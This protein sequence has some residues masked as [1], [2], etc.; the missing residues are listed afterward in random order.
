MNDR[1]VVP[2]RVDALALTQ[3][4]DV[5][6][7]SA[8]VAALPWFDGQRDHFARTPNLASA[9]NAPPFADHGARLQPGVHLHW[10]LPAGLTKGTT[11]PELD[12][13][14]EIDGITMPPA[15][16]RWLVRRLDPN[17]GAQWLIESDFVHSIQHEARHAVAFR[18]TSDRLPAVL[19]H[20]RIGRAIPLDNVNASGA[21]AESERLSTEEPWNFL[22]FVH[23]PLTALG[24]GDP[25]F[26][27]MYPAS[28]TVFGCHD[29]GTVTPG[30]ARYEVFGWYGGGVQDPLE[31]FLSSVLPMSSE[32]ALGLLNRRLALDGKTPLGP[33]QITG[34]ELAAAV[35]LSVKE[36]F[37]WDWEVPTDRVTEPLRLL[38]YGQV[39]VHTEAWTGRR[40]PVRHPHGTVV[41]VAD[42]PGE[43][44]GA[45]L[46]SSYPPDERAEIERRIA[47]LELADLL[48]ADHPDAAAKLAEARH[49]NRFS[50]VPG[51][52]YWALRPRTG[53]SGPVATNSGAP[54]APVPL[55][56]LATDLDALNEIQSRLDASRDEY[57][58]R[59]QELFA[60]W[61]RLMTA[62]YP[63]DASDPIPVDVDALRALIERDHLGP[64]AEL[65]ERGFA[66]EAR[67][68]DLHG[69]MGADL[70]AYNDGRPVIQQLELTL[71]PGA[72]FWRP[73]D[74]VVLLGDAD[75]MPIERHGASLVDG[76]LPVAKALRG[77]IEDFSDPHYLAGFTVPRWMWNSINEVTVPPWSP[78]VLEWEAEVRALSSGG[79]EQTVETGF[80]PQ[81]Y[82]P[83][84]VVANAA[85]FAD[86]PDL[87]PDPSAPVSMSGFEFVSG[88]S[89][90][91]PSAL[92]PIVADLAAHGFGDAE[93]E[94][95]RRAV[96]VPLGGLHEAL[97]MRNTEPQLAI[98]DP[99]GFGDQ[100]AFTARVRE[101][102]G[103]LHPESPVT[104]APFHPV[105]SGELLIERL[106]LLDAF[107]QTREWRPS[108]VVTTSDPF[109]EGTGGFAGAAVDRVR[110]APRLT[111]PARAH[112]RWLAADHDGLELNDH[113]A[114][115]PICGWIV[116]NVFDVA[117]DVHAADGELLGSIDDHGRWSPAPASV[118]APHSPSEIRNP[119][120][121]AVTKWFTDRPDPA[122]EIPEI[123]EHLETSLDA[124]EPLDNAAH[125]SRA[126]LGLP[127]I[128][129]SWE[130]LRHRL[131]GEPP[132]DHG[133]R[134][135][136]IPVRVGEH[137]QSN[138][139]TVA[140]W[141]TALD[142]EIGATLR[143][144]HDADEPS[145]TTTLNAAP[146][147]FTLLFDPRAALHIT[148]GILPTKSIV[149]P[150]ATWSEALENL[151]A[152]FRA[153]PLLM[154]PNE[155]AV[156]LPSE[157]GVSWS[158]Q[159][160]LERGW[161]EVP[162][163]P[164]VEF[165]AVV[166]AFPGRAVEL[167]RDGLE[168]GVLR[169]D[170][171]HPGRAVLA[172][173]APNTLGEE[174][175]RGLASIALE[176]RPADRGAR[177]GPPA[178]IREGWLQVRTGFADQLPGA[179]GTETG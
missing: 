24:S 131:L 152:A 116:P 28:R 91:N 122:R 153:A 39:R 149:L 14:V 70:A 19:R 137:Q 159:Q 51:H 129:Q 57:A 95:G 164:V 73:N 32:R 175:L 100:I 64:M 1:L 81:P 55:G 27:A 56:V 169:Q 143:F 48:D 106:R 87:V 117:L 68:R 54:L 128:D 173:D 167:W 110:L 170:P 109:G 142:G 178:T 138:D 41:A 80:D 83:D 120:L 108:E 85:L 172:L 86:H 76:A 90:L 96:A 89:V 13:G 127:A 102:L 71:M 26:S 44:F 20:V 72:R 34:D 168:S 38:C 11:H 179:A 67:L 165:A 123:I 113:P 46:A 155:I 141:P 133:V 36:R 50:P 146:L 69:R 114:T 104:G 25:L 62:V 43:A 78:L 163:Y 99:L 37:G 52:G 23:D 101:L 12:G 8:D 66:A 144:P 93:I 174:T 65:R 29:N 7:L 3:A 148:T 158:W 121:A 75:A 88:R 42:T 21:M 58:S 136:E 156:P 59:A 82:E 98:D 171:R 134:D 166:A 111:Q 47:V 2:I 132:S 135:V 77:I 151:A 84:F 119:H 107:G 97:L 112:A 49:A 124:I 160:R 33:E 145:F 9:I 177:F 45:F 161:L 176:I 35:R 115:S 94:L 74:P 18:P 6:D 92:Q 31:R 147:E 125:R 61:H 140:Y 15:P 126:L 30:T 40:P 162:E 5:V 79:N 17:P 63:R 105:R 4:I 157:P 130:H 118:D 60:D 22:P 154:P 53:G 139:G 10:S 16:N 103:D 150:P